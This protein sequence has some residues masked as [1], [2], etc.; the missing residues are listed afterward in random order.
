MSYCVKGVVTGVLVR[1][2]DHKGH[3]SRQ[4][5]LTAGQPPAGGKDSDLL[6]MGGA[7]AQVTTS[8]ELG[9]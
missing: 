9:V 3:G 2:L 1:S 4:E 5:G 8:C 7:Q 6:P